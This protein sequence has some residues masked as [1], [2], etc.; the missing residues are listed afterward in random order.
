VNSSVMTGSTQPSSAISFRNLGGELG[1]SRD[2]KVGTYVVLPP[3]S[4]PLAHSRVDVAKVCNLHM[5]RST[6]LRG[7]VARVTQT[8]YVEVQQARLIGYY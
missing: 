4:V 6:S 1:L 2:D 3:P 5:R 7:L 8:A